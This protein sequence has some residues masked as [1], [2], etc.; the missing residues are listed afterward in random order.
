MQLS[1]TRLLGIALILGW[2]V[3]AVALAEA[4]SD[5]EHPARAVSVASKRTLD[6]SGKPRT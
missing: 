6:H 4:G 1:A 2:S 5:G 3:C